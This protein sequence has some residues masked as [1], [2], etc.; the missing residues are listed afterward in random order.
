MS[1]TSAILTI[2]ALPALADPVV[3]IDPGS[4][5]RFFRGK[6]EASSP[7]PTTWRTVGFSDTSWESGPAPLGYGEAAIVTEIDDMW[8]SYTSLFLRQAFEVSNAAVVNTLTVNMKYDDGLVL[9]INGEEVLR[10]NMPSNPGDPV[11]Y[12]DLAMDP[13]EASR[14]DE[15]P[16]PD[17]G[18]YLVDGTN[19]IAVQVFNTPIRSTDL[20]FDLELFDPFGP[21]VKP[22]SVTSIFPSPGTTLRSLTGIE[23]TFSEDV[24]GVDPFDLVIQGDPASE[25]TGSGPGPYVF[26]CSQPPA[27]PVLVE[28]DSGHGI[29]DLAGA[30]NAFEG[31]GWT[32][33]LDPDAPVGNLIISEF[34]AANRTGLQDEDGDREDWIEIYNAGDSTVNVG[35]WSV[36]D[37]PDD[38]GKYTLPPSLLGPQEYLVIFASGK[39]RRVP[40]SKLHTNFK[41]NSDGEYLGLFPPD[42]PRR[43][44]SEYSPRFPA[45]RADFSYGIDST[46][47]PAYFDPPTPGDPNGSAT[48]FEGFVS[49]PRS[50]FPR[51][52]YR[53]GFSI[54]LSS[55]TPGATIYYTLDGREPSPASHQY[56]EPIPV[57]GSPNKAAVTIRAVAYKNGYL[58]SNVVT[59]SYIFPEHVPAQPDRPAGFPLSWGI[60]PAVDYGMDPQIVNDPRYRGIIVE[61]LLAI[62][63]LSIVMDVND[64]FGPRGIYSNPQGEGIAYERPCSAELIHP[65]GAEG[66]QTNCGIRIQG[67]ASRLP[68]KSPKHGLR[69][70]FKGAYGPTKLRY[71]FFPDSRVEIFDTI[72]LRA[73][74]NNSWI[75]WNGAQR[76]RGQKIRDQWARDT[77]LAMGRLSSHGTYMHVYI[78]GLY[79]GLYNPVERPTAPFAADHLGGDKEE[80]DALNSG[81][82]VDGNKISWNV[83]MNLANGGLSSNAQ[84]LNIQEHL[85][86]PGLIDYMIINIYGYNDDWPSHNWYAVRKREAGAQYRFISWD[87]E[88]ILELDQLN[89]NKINVSDNETP[90]RLYSQ[91]RANAEFRLLFADHLHRHFFNG[92]VLTPGKIAE[93]WMARAN[94]IEKAIV[95]ESARWGDYRRDVHPWSSGPY[96]LYDRD[97][98]WIREQSNLL[99]LYF[100]RRSDIVLNQFR[101]AGLYPSVG[102]PIFNKHGGEIDPGF[103]LTMTLPPG[104]SGTIFYTTDGTDPRIFGTG[105]VAAAAVS[106]EGPVVLNDTTLVKARILSGNTWSA[107]TEA[108]FTISEP[109]GQLRVTEIM[110]HPPD[111][112]PDSPFHAEDFEFI[113][114]QNIGSSTLDLTGLYFSNGMEFSFAAN[115]SVPPGG[116]LVLASNEAAFASRYPGVPITGIFTGKLDNG[117]EK[118]TLKDGT[119]KTV[120]SVDYDDED[121]WPLGADGFGFSL[122]SLDPAGNPDDPWNWRASTAVQ[123]SPGAADPDPLHDGVI[124]NEVLTRSSPPLE[125]A[126]ELLNTRNQPVDIGGWFLS[127]SREDAL[128]LKKFRIPEGTVVPAVGYMVLYENQ[129]NPQPGMFPSFDLNGNGGEVYLASAAADG[130]LTGH[131]VGHRFMGAEAGVSFGRYPTSNGLDFTALESRSFGEDRPSSVEEF[132]KGSGAPNGDPKVGPVVI[133]EIH[134]H[135]PYG[136]DEFVEL[137]N[138]T[139]NSIALHDAGTGRGWRLQGVRN[140]QETGEYEFPPGTE[141][142]SGGYLLLVQIDPDLFR[143]SY[144]VPASVVIHGPYGGGLD[145]AG[146]WL[147]LLRPEG[148]EADIVVDRVRYNDQIPWAQEPDG[149]GPSLERIASLEYG[150]DP[151]NW[152]ASIPVGGTPGAHNSV[153]GTGVNE[154]PTAAFTFQEQEY[155]LQVLFDASKSRDPDGMIVSYEWDF[156][157]GST[158][159]GKTVLH[160][161]AAPSIYLVKLTVRDDHDA[162]ASYHRAVTILFDGGW[163]LPGDSNQDNALDISDAISLLWRLFLT[164][165]IPLPCEGANLQEGGNR[166]LLNVNGDANVDVSDVVHILNYL[167]RGGAAPTLG[168]NCIFI[169][170]CMDTC[171]SVP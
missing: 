12:N 115:T 157:D 167:F 47:S 27:G 61:S 86:V 63:S 140:A 113:E 131:I 78:N 165:S 31:G 65:D 33:T 11:A 110:Y 38:P 75:H 43:A 7:D 150:N 97:T 50:S 138:P 117:G 143:D 171:P 159:A 57:E 67:G 100:P 161:F 90:A 71:P 72:T 163:Q 14:W 162:E 5:W 106:Y 59:F 24:K 116:F 66:F 123:G 96:Y 125:D 81:E 95:A 141:I 107:V 34:L 44:T 89:S 151:A 98:Y 73:D 145:N 60:A 22:P 29:T 166:I 132:R 160:A 82:V 53:E 101:T 170:G 30:P 54:E 135:P 20:F 84:Y 37:D 16:L 148:A 74:F 42:L 2:L 147:A 64:M 124:I 79:W 68:E 19:V 39:D 108:L 149:G 26:S 18:D 10:V 13:R 28:W 169:P 92:G 114:F 9:W 69:F 146:E 3:Y 154:E 21:D 8:D 103:I 48:V 23:V 85:D 55:L 126:V 15:F 155:P 111:P 52:F 168:S 112:N 130:T 128:G 56:A 105:G 4:T 77:Q 70:L 102:A 121:F 36:T 158:G 41:V 49:D 46:G 139:G 136:E 129:F 76:V 137:H 58:P 40:D 17:P 94:Q 127:D 87:A 83:M 1:L 152:G 91:L 32:Y 51:G 156:G 109:A 118:V 45:Q 133:N 6:T 142:P 144:G 104:T 153:S 120:I 93:R 88:R 99:N 122:V 25:V 80:Y 134:Y 62:P 35:G 119:G 164:D